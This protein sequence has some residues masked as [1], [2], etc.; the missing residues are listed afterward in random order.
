MR[1]VIGSLGAM[2]VGMVCI[3]VALANIGA[4]PAT[5]GQ[6][7]D[8]LIFSSPQQSGFW[9]KGFIVQATPLTARAT[10]IVLYPAYPAKGETIGSLLLPIL[11]ETLPIVEGTGVDELKKGVGHFAQSALPGEA[12]NCVLSGHRDTVFSQL[13]RLQIGDE[14]IV[15][16][17]A[18][19]FT[20][21]VNGIRIVDKEDRTVIVHANHAML[22]LTTCYPFDFVGSAQN[23][24]IV[25]AD[26]VK[27]Q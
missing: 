4:Q 3:G 6:V 15:Q 2:I 27:S 23:R 24:Y 22:T 1:G 16:T 11:N 14:V 13:G 8:S 12:D 10:P 9:A 21:K 25:T 7:Y 26:W 5:F 18:G 17:L 20:Y 19:T